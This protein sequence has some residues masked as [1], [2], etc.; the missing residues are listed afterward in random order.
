[1]GVIYRACETGRNGIIVV[2]HCEHIEELS[3]VVRVVP[4]LLQPYWEVLVIE[5]L[6]DELGVTAY[7]KSVNRYTVNLETS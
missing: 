2:G 7:R 5:A 1:M 6:C 3:C 4:R